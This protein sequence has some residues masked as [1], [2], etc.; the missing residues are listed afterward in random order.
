MAD[1]ISGKVNPSGKLATT[2]PLDYNDVPSAKNFPGIEFPEKA[3]TGMMGMKLTPA[4]VT[5]EEGIYIGYRYFNTF[6]KKTAYEFGYGLS[7]TNFT[8]SNLKLSGSNFNNELTVSV[9]IT[10]SGKIAGKEAVQLYL[11]APGKTMDK[12]S[13]ELKAFAKTGLL[14]PGKSQTISFTITASDLASFDT[15]S[16]S[17]LAEA[18]RYTVKIGASS[19]NIKQLATFDLA[20][21]L[22]VE[23]VNKV[24]VPQVAINELKP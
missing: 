21:E 8:Y 23:K 13:E 24:L 15:K 7:Y 6:Q 20:K 12:P 16:S 5:Y 4:E 18:G 14:S 22:L 10:N 9:T 19:N 2:F 3:E 1:I 11:S 17:W